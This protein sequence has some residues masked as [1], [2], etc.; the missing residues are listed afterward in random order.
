MA[1]M[2]PTTPPMGWN[3]W[4]CYGASVTEAEVLAN[5]DY[6]ASNLSAHGYEYIVVDIQWYEPQADGSR[7][8]PFA[9]LAMDAWGRLMPAT[10]RFPSTANG[11]G[12]APLA[13]R[14]HHM[15]LKFG[16]HILR[17]IPRQA[18][19]R[20]SPILGQPTLTARD[21][22]LPDSV[23]P[24]NADMYGLN[25]QHP[26]SQAYYDSLFA[27]YALWGVDFV[28]VDDIAWS[29][30]YGY[31]GGEVE[32]IHHAIEASGRDMV[33]SLSPGPSSLTHARHLE[34]HATMWRV[35]DDFWDQWVQLREAFDFA[36]AWAPFEHPG[37][38]PDLDM[39]PLG[40]LA[41]RSSETGVGDRWTRLTPDE[42]RTM[43]SLWA[44]TRSPLMV[45][46][47]LRDNDAW[48]L[49]LLTNDEVLAVHRQSYGAREVFRNAESSVWMA[50]HPDGQSYYFALFNWAD[51]PR[52][53]AVPWTADDPQADFT[54]RDLWAQVSEV[55][56]AKPMTVPAHGARLLSITAIP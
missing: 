48:T 51:E 36:S 28:K 5:A 53:I 45:G 54:L 42:Q 32:L 26:G 14:I 2:K 18:V 50:R 49:S 10:N 38:Y 24:W 44:I 43:M 34:T 29:R 20:N 56:A 55:W 52:D 25:P 31:H 17:G 1:L 6:M 22:A 33:L 23:C 4:D 11:Q 8:H 9:D 30:L 41:L 16:I 40:H 13:D 35:S 19:H 27:L 12:F 15:G 7:Y 37:S 39:L 46:G 47:E 21:I 3:S